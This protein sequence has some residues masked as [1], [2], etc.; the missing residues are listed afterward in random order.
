MPVARLGGSERPLHRVPVQAGLD[1]CIVGYINVVIVIDEGVAANRVVQR[2]CRNHE[3][4]AQGPSVLLDPMHRGGAG[5]GWR[6]YLRCQ[7]NRTHYFSLSSQIKIPPIFG[8]MAL[9]SA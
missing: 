9:L 4:K 2:D 7:A 5:M 3:Q 1:L 8:P 6:C